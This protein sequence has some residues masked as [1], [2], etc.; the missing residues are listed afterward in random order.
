M[1]PCVLL[2]CSLR[3]IEANIS[4]HSYGGEGGD[5]PVESC[6]YHR[7]CFSVHSKRKGGK[8]VLAQN[9]ENITQMAIRTGRRLFSFLPDQHIDLKDPFWLFLTLFS[10]VTAHVATAQSTQLRVTTTGHSQTQR[11]PSQVFR[12]MPST[13]CYSFLIYSYRGKFLQ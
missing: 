10:T 8:E 5:V 4:R 13:F 6:L 2:R 3:V 11:C 12:L 1:R 9:Y 7:S